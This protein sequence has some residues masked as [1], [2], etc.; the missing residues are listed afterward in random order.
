MAHARGRDAVNYS[1]PAF[2]WQAEPTATARALSPVARIWG[3]LAER[4][5][6]RRPSYR[7]P[8][9]VVCVGNFVVGGAGKTPT[10]LALARLAR[11]RGLKPGMLASGY[12]GA[13]RAPVLVDPAVHTADV[14]GDEALLLAAAA[15]TVVSRDRAAGARRLVEA[16]VDIIIMDDGFQNPSLALDLALVA[17]DAASG[18][19]NGMTMPAGPL[20]LPLTPQMRRADALLVVGEGAAAEP[21]VRAAAR[22]GRPVLRATI[23]PARARD[24]RKE[25]ILAYA[26][27]GHPE[28]F[29]ASLRAAAAPVAK[30]LSFADHYQYGEVDAAKLLQIADR[31]KLRL[32]TT[33]KDLVR[34]SGRTGALGQL[35]ERS[36]AF[37]VV[38]EFEN[39]AAVSA[40]ID[41]AVGSAALAQGTGTRA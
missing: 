3:A 23:T 2:W 11:A 12:G 39:P 4:R 22:A 29:F 25:P 26:G 13:A 9:P 33:E 35:R 15:P 16:G 7:A 31:E 5:M 27:I 37:H 30:T 8:V 36:E 41:A 32:V 38:L 17:V 40:M 20:R 24:W 10:A 28:K 19:G 34:L 6:L 21:L 1:A 18:I 14:V